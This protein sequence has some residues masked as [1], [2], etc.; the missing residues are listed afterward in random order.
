MPIYT[1]IAGSQILVPYWYSNIEGASK[2]LTSCIANE[3]GVSKELLITPN[4]YWRFPPYESL[5]M[6]PNTVTRMIADT[7]TVDTNGRFTLLNPTLYQGVPPVGKLFVVSIDTGSNTYTGITG[8]SIYCC[9]DNDRNYLR[10]ILTNTCKAN[11]SHNISDTLLSN[12]DVF[13]DNNCLYIKKSLLP[14]IFKYN[15]NSISYNLTVTSTGLTSLESVY[16]FTDETPYYIWGANSYS[17]DPAFITFNVNKTYKITKNNIDSH[18]G[19]WIHDSVMDDR[20]YLYSI[21]S[22]D[23]EETDSYGQLRW[24]IYP[25]EEVRLDRSNGGKLLYH[26]YSI[27][28]KSIGYIR[29][30]DAAYWISNRTTLN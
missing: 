22:Y 16:P 14:S 8:S 19:R 5:V 21:K 3:N 2:Q 27:A 29:L 24:L 26:G 23:R 28:N 18:I 30:N 10:F 15:L 9:V 25:K 11:T 13:Y 20:E 7:A 4:E 17:I 12:T 6:S 1:N